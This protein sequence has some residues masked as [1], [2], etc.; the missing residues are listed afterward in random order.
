MCCF[1]LYCIGYS[2]AIKN[3]SA[4]DAQFAARDFVA[5]QHR[6]RGECAMHILY[7]CLGGFSIE[8]NTFN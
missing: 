3:R 5:E 1:F 4:K 6:S 8:M 7:Y 2:Y